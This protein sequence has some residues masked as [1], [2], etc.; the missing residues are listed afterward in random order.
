MWYRVD[1]YRIALHLLPTFLRRTLLFALTKV[2][3]TGLVDISRSFR[4]FCITTRQRLQVN[5]QV[6]YIEKALND[7][8]LLTDNEIFI[9]DLQNFRHTVY[10]RNNEPATYF[11]NDLTKP[12]YIENADINSQMK[13]I[14]N[15][16]SFLDGRTEEIKTIVDFNK[17][18]GREYIIKVY[19]YE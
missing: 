11:S 1:F 9:T 5:G 7:Y 6:I 15:V 2:I 4:T 18:A 12:L 14:V 19:S 13:F 17:P 10:I 16:P 3:L 8:F